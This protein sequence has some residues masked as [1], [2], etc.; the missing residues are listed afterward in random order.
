MSNISNMS[1]IWFHQHCERVSPL[2][3]VA[4]TV[5]VGEKRFSSWTHAEESHCLYCTKL[6]M[7]CSFVFCVLVCWSIWWTKTQIFHLHDCQN[8]IICSLESH[9]IL[10]LSMGTKQPSCSRDETTS[11]VTIFFV[12]WIY[13]KNLHQTNLFPG[14]LL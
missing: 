12:I 5:C 8:T 10:W 1:L 3:A 2:L 14:A 6:N 4:F 9:L 13:N 7:L 11:L